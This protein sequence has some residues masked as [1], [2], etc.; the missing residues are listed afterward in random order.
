MKG[1]GK[2]CALGAILNTGERASLLRPEDGYGQSYA[3][4]LKNLFYNDPAIL[5]NPTS[6]KTTNTFG[7]T[8]KKPSERMNENCLS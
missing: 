1:S 3:T 4:Q 5:P 6:E 8:L 2:T 7:F